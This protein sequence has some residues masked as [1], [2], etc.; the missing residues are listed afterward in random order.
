MSY[1][2]QLQNRMNK[3][4]KGGKEWGREFFISY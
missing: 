2:E 4:E 1:V 3:I